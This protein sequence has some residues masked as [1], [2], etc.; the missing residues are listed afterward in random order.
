MHIAMNAWFWDQPY[1]GS[2]QYLHQLVKALR[3]IESSLKIT[4]IMPE[5]IKS[6]PGV[7]SGVEVVP[8]RVPFGGQI[9]KVLFEQQTYPAAVR[10]TGAEIAHVPYWGAPLSSP[11]RLVVTIHDV[12]P[13]SM[14]IYQG[15]FGAKLYF[16]L[17]TASAKGVAHIITDSEFSK[18]EIIE[19]I[20]F[21]AEYTTSILL[22]M[23][24]ENH[25]RMGQERDPQIREKYNLPDEYVLYMGGFDVR[26]N[27][28]ALL[29]AYTFV[30]PAVGED[31]PLVLG[32]P[33]PA[34]WG[35]PRFP[36]L[37][38]EVERLKLKDFVRWIGPVDEADKPGVYRMAKVFVYP[39]RYEGF[40]L[41]PLEAMA[42]GTPTVAADAS[43]LPEVVGDGAYLVD[44]DDSRKMGG[45]IIATLIQNDLR[46]SLRNLGLARASNF[47]W[48]RTAR[49]TLA[50]Y[51]QVIERKD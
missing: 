51:R 45:A 10:R 20:G 40:G 24:P 35:T 43:S 50:V 25:P 39:S 14:P 41:G 6:P 22:A 27:V 3:Q 44:P 23:S 46:E 29:S 42:N 15:S 30:G 37:R 26:K 49:E 9:G 38:A 21:P 18:K 5:H 16:S 2:G 34:H 32:G 19:R 12:I 4:L 47:S 17:V 13:L 33:E 11:A 31:I 8:A 28:R 36:D 1:T 7:P 48:Q